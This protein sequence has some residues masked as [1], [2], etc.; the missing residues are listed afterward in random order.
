MT[1]LNIESIGADWCI[2][3]IIKVKLNQYGSFNTEGANIPENKLPHL[4][5]T[6]TINNTTVNLSEA[7][8]LDEIRGN[9]LNRENS[10]GSEIYYECK[11]VGNELPIIGIRLDNSF[12]PIRALLININFNQGHPVQP[13]A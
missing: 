9:S 13:V 7:Y 3:D 12:K 8:S 4:K 6:L 1:E 2:D 11:F 10:S 5:G